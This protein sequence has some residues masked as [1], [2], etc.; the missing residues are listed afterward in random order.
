MVT[1][2]RDAWDIADDIIEY[3]YPDFY[4]KG[5]GWWG[6][7]RI[8]NYGILRGS[9]ITAILID[10]EKNNKTNQVRRSR[11]RKHNA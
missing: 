8:P 10:R 3:I 4:H 1:S 2:V 11:H 7:Q 6:A 9:I 5:K